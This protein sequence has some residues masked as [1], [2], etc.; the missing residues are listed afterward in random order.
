MGFNLLITVAA[1]GCGFFDFY[2]VF[3]VFVFR[4]GTFKCA[5]MAE[6]SLIEKK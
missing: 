3:C 5:T 1:L 6:K 4:T 2:V